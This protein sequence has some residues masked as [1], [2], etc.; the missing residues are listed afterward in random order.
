VDAAGEGRGIS[1]TTNHAGSD[2]LYV[3]SSSTTFESDR[4]YDKFA[5]YA[6]L[7]HPGD[8]AVAARGAAF[9]DIL[10]SP[11]RVLVTQAD[12]LMAADDPPCLRGVE[13]RERTVR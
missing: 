12:H 10:H 9:T 2:L 11:A 5:T 13:R 8:F 1:A 3:F 4:A 6:V 7:N